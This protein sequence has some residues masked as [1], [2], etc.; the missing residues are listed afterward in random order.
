[1][2][3]GPCTK[4][5]LIQQEKSPSVTSAEV[6]LEANENS[7][8][9]LE[10]NEIDLP[11][12]E[13]NRGSSNRTT[14]A[15]GSVVEVDV[16]DLHHEAPSRDSNGES[17]GE[18]L[19]SHCDHQRQHAACVI[20]QLAAAVA[21]TLVQP[22]EVGVASVFW[23]GAQSRFPLT[24]QSKDWKSSSSDI[25]AAGSTVGGEG[26]APMAC[27]SPSPGL[28]TAGSAGGVVEQ[29][30]TSG[31]PA[32]QTKARSRTCNDP[33]AT[34]LT[35]E[36]EDDEDGGF[37]EGMCSTQVTG[38]SLAASEL[39]EGIAEQA[40]AEGIAEQVLADE[41]LLREEEDTT[42]EM[43]D[44][45]LERQRLQLQL[46]RKMRELGRIEAEHAALRRNQVCEVAPSWRPPP[47]FCFSAAGAASRSWGSRKPAS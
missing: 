3:A 17:E 14:L 4:T 2:E 1:M 25:A 47:P 16:G 32:T 21:P 46:E 38:V 36:G 12:Q 8:A 44:M 27:P 26:E 22:P 42:E 5:I 24:S 40:L 18:G 31:F 23:E 29:N 45:V 41:D 6:S 37:H 35:G 15:A 33:T 11:R 43:M 10:P 28:E 20:G 34:G 19:Q 39:A 30:S 13:Q 9:L 7:K